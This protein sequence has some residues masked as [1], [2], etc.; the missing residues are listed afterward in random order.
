ME[1][2]RRQVERETFRAE[3]PAAVVDPI[4]GRDQPSAVVMA[5]PLPASTSALKSCL[6][7]RCFLPDLTK[8]R[9]HPFD[10]N[11][12]PLMMI[13]QQVLAD[14]FEEMK[15][16]EPVRNPGE[17]FCDGVF[18]GLRHVAYDGGRNPEKNL[19][20]FEDRD[21][22]VLSF[23]RDF[24]GVNHIAAHSVPYHEMRVFPAFVCPVQ[25]DEEA[26][27]AIKFRQSCRSGEVAFLQIRESLQRELRNGACRDV[28]EMFF[29]YMP[30]NLLPLHEPDIAQDCHEKNGVVGEIISRRSYEAQLSGNDSVP[31]PIRSDA[32]FHRELPQPD[33]PYRAALKPVSGGVFQFFGGEGQ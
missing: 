28:E 33:R 13:G 6:F 19:H 27:P 25:V 17:N 20:S 9:F 7:R 1:S 18:D 10:R 2:E 16:A 30:L 31:G 21:D 4:Y 12:H 3:I 26:L 32:V 15:M 29:E 14:G 8:G 11:A 5:F 22:G 23:G 24:F